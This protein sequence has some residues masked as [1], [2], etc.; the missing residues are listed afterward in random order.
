MSSVK[1]RPR[2]LGLNVLKLERTED[3]PWLVT[4]GGLWWLC[5]VVILAKDIEE[6]LYI[7]NIQMKLNLWLDG[8]N[9]TFVY[10]VPQRSSTWA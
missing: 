5:H 4:V 7:S 10:S 6:Y 1:R 3:T 8:R 9:F 2:C